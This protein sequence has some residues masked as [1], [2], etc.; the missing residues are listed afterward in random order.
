MFLN[1]KAIDVLEAI[2]PTFIASL[3]HAPAR[4]KVEAEPSTRSEMILRTHNAITTLR[5]EMYRLSEV[6]PKNHTAY[7]LSTTDHEE[8]TSALE[9]LFHL[10]LGCLD[11]PTDSVELHEMVSMRSMDY[12][13][14]FISSN[15]CRQA[16]LKRSRMS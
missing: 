4:N 12:Y 15:A 16:H 13:A 10:F 3:P 2:V 11:D 7:D 5:F 9:E 8:A 14:L 6:I 1:T